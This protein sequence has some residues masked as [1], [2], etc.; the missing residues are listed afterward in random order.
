M[1]AFDKR[2]E[3]SLKS[4]HSP[5]PNFDSLRYLIRELRMEKEGTDQLITTEL[6]DEPTKAPRGNRIFNVPLY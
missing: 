2:F 1:L 3:V 4:A 5:P 6:R